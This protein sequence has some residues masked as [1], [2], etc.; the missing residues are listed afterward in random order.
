MFRWLRQESGRKDERSIPR[1]SCG[2]LPTVTDLDFTDC[3]RPTTFRY[4]INKHDLLTENNARSLCN[5]TIS[6]PTIAPSPHL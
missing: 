6:Y 4:E 1:D 5:K 2:C 3:C